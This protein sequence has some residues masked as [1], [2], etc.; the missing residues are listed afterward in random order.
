MFGVVGKVVW[1]EDELIGGGVDDGM[2]SSM[3]KRVKC[4]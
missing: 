1:V 4:E 2:K 3:V